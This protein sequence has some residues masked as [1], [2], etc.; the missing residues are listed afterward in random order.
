[1]STFTYNE[2]GGLSYFMKHAISL[3]NVD[4]YDCF[5]TIQ[6]APLFNIHGDNENNL[7]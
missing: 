5:I 1:M 3:Q 7:N 4:V 6:V 2:S